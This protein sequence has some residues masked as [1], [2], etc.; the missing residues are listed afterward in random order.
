MPRPTLHARGLRD[1]ASRVA[2]SRE[3]N[4]DVDVIACL[5]M[6]RVATMVIVAIV[7]G[8]RDSTVQAIVRGLRLLASEVAARLRP[9]DP[10]TAALSP[11]SEALRPDLR[12]LRRD[13]PLATRDSASHAVLVFLGRNRARRVTTR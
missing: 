4:V 7:R 13:R 12:G 1:H 8:L 11:T 3:D 2:I 5:H 9:R 6:T 10:G